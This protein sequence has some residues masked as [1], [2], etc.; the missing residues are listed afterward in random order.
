[1]HSHKLHCES[2]KNKIQET[3]RL[4]VLLVLALLKAPT[5][6]VQLVQGL[7]KYAKK[8]HLFCK[9]RIYTPQLL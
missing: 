1:M 6:P 7:I 3:S 9:I 4:V 8:K 2:K 5:S